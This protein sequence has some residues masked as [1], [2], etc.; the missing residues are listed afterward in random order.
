MVNPYHNRSAIR[1]DR[2]FI[3]RQRD[4][5]DIMALIAAGQPQSIAI[6]G[7]RRIGKSTLLQAICRRLRPMDD[8]VV[9]YQD[10][11]GL[12]T[13]EEFFQSLV[14]QLAPLAGDS[15]VP[16]CQGSSNSLRYYVT[17][18]SKNGKR[19]VILLDEFDAIA[20]NKNFSLLFFSFLRSLPNDW[21]VSLVLASPNKLRDI[22]SSQEIAGS[23][24]FNI[25]YERRLGSFK[26]QESQELICRLSAENGLS[27]EPYQ[28]FILGLAG[29]WPFFLQVVSYLVFEECKKVED[30]APDLA[31]IEAIAYEELLIAP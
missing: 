12:T 22:C 10:V 4:L 8:Y 19:I 24:F 17:Q 7:D 11:Q 3:G 20:R 6:V 28:E 29:D 1:D 18:L 13:E 15:A 30:V 27:L 16:P 5:A 9:V 25:F 26:R 2:Y 21:P 14:V 23:P 31:V